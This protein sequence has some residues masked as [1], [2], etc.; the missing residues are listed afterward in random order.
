MAVP[1][2]R[3]HDEHIR[4]ERDRLDGRAGRLR[5]GGEVRL[6]EHHHGDGSQ[7]AT[8]AESSRSMRR[9]L[10]GLGDRM[11]DE[12][13]VDVGGQHLDVGGLPGIA[14]RDGARALSSTASMSG[15]IEVLGDQHGHPVA[16]RR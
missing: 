13:G 1:G 7:R 9:R 11:N 3:V 8:A 10:G 4:A 14:A 2:K 6:G 12:H 5:I 15:R 16:D